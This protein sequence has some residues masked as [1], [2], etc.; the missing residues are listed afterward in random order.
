MAVRWS[1]WRLK[2][3][4]ILFPRAWTSALARW[5]FYGVVAA[6]VTLILV[7]LIMTVLPLRFPQVYGAVDIG[8]PAGLRFLWAVPLYAFIA[9][10]IGIAVGSLVRAPAAAVAVVLFWVHLAENSI[11][12]LPNG[13][14]L[15]AYAPFL[16]S[17]AATGQEMAFLPRF[18]PAGSLI[19]FL[20]V[21]LVL[22]LLSAVVRAAAPRRPRRRR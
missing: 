11:G 9:C 1:R 2:V 17:V 10:G 12:L 4:R 5:I 8:S 22:F 18:G 19:Y 15:Q 6:L 14:A 13:Y 21:A 20:T 3:A 16:N 7:V